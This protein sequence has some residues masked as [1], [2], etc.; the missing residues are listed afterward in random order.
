MIIKN[1]GLFI[2]SGIFLFLTKLSTFGIN[3][4]Q[5]G[6][7]TFQHTSSSAQQNHL[8]IQLTFCNLFS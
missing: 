1:P 3:C 2:E 7:N 8:N 4:N 6:A 5:E